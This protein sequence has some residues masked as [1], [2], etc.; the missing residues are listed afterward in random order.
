VV[1][2]RSYIKPAHGC[3]NCSANFSEKR[4]ATSA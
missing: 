1:R 4:L 2:S 3:V